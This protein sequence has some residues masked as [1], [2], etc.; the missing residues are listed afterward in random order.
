MKSKE[1]WKDRLEVR[2]NNKGLRNGKNKCF[3][4]DVEYAADNHCCYI[5]NLAKEK[6]HQSLILN[7]HLV[8]SL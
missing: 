8:I 4:N 3:R 5:V 6:N 7:C 2:G 1:A